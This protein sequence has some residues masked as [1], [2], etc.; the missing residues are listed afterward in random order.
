ME[1]LYLNAPVNSLWQNETAIGVPVTLT[2]IGSDGT[3]C[4]LGTV[5][6][7]GYYGTF[8]YTWTPAKADSYTVYTAFAG[9]D[10]YGLSSA[11][12]SVSI[13]AAAITPTTAPTQT[14][15]AEPDY[16]MTIIG[17]G[18][19]IIIAVAIVGMLMLR[20]RA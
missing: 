6:T 9:D 12:T 13:G 15:I 16:S 19:A 3:V 5:T 7:N 1:Y 20:K 18:I 8:S 11:A 2:A 14:A 10:S 17:M 4:N